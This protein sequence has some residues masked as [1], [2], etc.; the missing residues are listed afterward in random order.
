MFQG[1]EFNGNVSGWDVSNVKLM[2]GIFSN[3]AFRGNVSDWDVRGLA[4][5]LFESFPD[6]AEKPYWSLIKN[7]DDR[8]AAVSKYFLSKSLS[9]LLEHNRYSV[10]FEREEKAKV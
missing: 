1:S 7:K 8:D 4:G 5:D 3:S 9:N 6:L 10:E 2:D